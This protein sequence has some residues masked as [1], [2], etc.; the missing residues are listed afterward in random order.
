MGETTAIAWCDHTFNPWRGCQRVSEGCR[1]CYAESLMHRWGLDGLWGP[2]GERRRTTPANWRK[3]LAWNRQAA[4]TGTRPRV[5]C[6]SL[7]DVFEDHPDANAARPEL[8]ELVGST[9]HLDWLLLTKRPENIARM[10][11]H[12]WTIL[13]MPNVWLGTSVEDMRVASRV[14]ALRSVR[15]AVR[16]ISYE[17]ALGP[18]DDLDLSGIDWVIYGGESGADFRSDDRDWAR[19]MRDRCQQA[20][21]AFFYKQASGR[22]PG[23]ETLLDGVEHH[24]WPGVSA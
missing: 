9:P 19:T 24:E 10:L 22:F 6:S 13:P 2:K 16:F 1:H 8:W 18:L 5:F 15:A 12:Q 7:A 3:P 20:G 17:P 14:D 23:R 21:I 11:P 4:A